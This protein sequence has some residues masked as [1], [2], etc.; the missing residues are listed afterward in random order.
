MNFVKGHNHVLSR[1]KSHLYTEVAA[2]LKWRFEENPMQ[3]YHVVST[4]DWYIAMY[5][6]KHRFFKEL[7]I[8]EV[9]STNKE[10]T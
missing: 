3:K 1:K 9:I 7:R 4:N 8:V 6:K 2:Y 10:W 5:I